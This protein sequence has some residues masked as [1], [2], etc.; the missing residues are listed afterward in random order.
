MRK[1]VE[2]QWDELPQIWQELLDKD[3]NATPFQDYAFLNFTGKGKPQRKDMLRLI[4]LKEL[5]LVLY[6]DNEVTAIAP[7]LFKKKNNKSIV[8]FRGH[9]TTASQLDFIFDPEWSY[10]DFAFLMDGIKGVLG[11]V[12]YFLDRVS[13]H[14][15]TSAYLKRY[16]KSPKIE[17][18]DCYAIPVTEQY[19]EWF[20]NLHRHTRKNLNRR[21]NLLITECRNA[22]KVFVC[23][24]KIDAKTSRQMMNIYAQRFL[25]KNKFQF[26]ALTF[27]VKQVLIYILLHDKMTYWL[28]NAPNSYHLILYANNEIVAFTSGLIT[29]NKYIVFSRLAINS[30]YSKYGPGGLLM[31]YMMQYVIEQ[32]H[33]GNMDI[34]HL[35]LGQGGDNGMEYKQAFGGK[36]HHKYTFY[37]FD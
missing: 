22:Q 3:P 28:N 23:G 15:A 10:E 19:D 17:D 36:L 4:G 14:S 13:E 5:N 30:K 8:Y 31:N 6:N 29:K 33:N 12:H 24:D 20:L 25:E 18:H 2:K 32:N 34:E 26:G 16:L 9:F 37:T 21:N 27:I 7:L 11:T 1:I 35:D